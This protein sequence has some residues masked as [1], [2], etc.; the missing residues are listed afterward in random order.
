VIRSSL[1][2]VRALVGPRPVCSRINCTT[3]P[4]MAEA[5]KP[6]G[7]I[8]MSGKDRPPSRPPLVTGPGEGNEETEWT[9]YAS[10]VF[11][12]APQEMSARHELTWI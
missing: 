5:T 7:A 2:Y 1:M 4:E 11:P 9:P 10:P 8:G 6:L 12:S 3:A